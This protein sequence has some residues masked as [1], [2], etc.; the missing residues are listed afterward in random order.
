MGL[1]EAI[2]SGS[3]WRV[4]QALAKRDSTPSELAKRFGTSIANIT[5]QLSKLES[6]GLVKR[7]GVKRQGVGRPF[8]RY[9]LDR[10]FVLLIGV[11]PGKAEKVLLEADE[12]IRLHLN[13][14][15]IPQ[16]EYHYYVEKF[17]WDIQDYL[18]SIEALA[19]FGS[20]AKGDARAGSDIDLL[21]IARK[22]ARRLERK[23]SS[24]IVGPEGRGKM[25]MAQVF[26]TR[27]F[28]NMQKSGSRFAVEAIS[29]M[30]V[31][32]DPNGIL[33]VLR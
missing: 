7:V 15:S 27:E 20:V 22:N 11:I 29:S 10:G 33:E 8:T 4:I 16:K 18:D 9:S 32:Y 2:S 28:I 19:V 13:I 24:K 5:Q 25:I 21:I 14:W 6:E 3:R 31:I 30:K 17:W 23:F 12:N 26:S 1:L